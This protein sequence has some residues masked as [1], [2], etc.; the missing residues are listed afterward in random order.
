MPDDPAKPP[1][2]VPERLDVND[3]PRVWFW[4]IQLGVTREQLLAAIKEV[5][6]LIADVR[7]QLGK[8]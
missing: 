4:A 8:A 5:G 3:F 2:P 6:P 7:K 1:I